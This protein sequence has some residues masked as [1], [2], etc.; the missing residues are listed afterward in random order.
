[1]DLNFQEYK[2]AKV[3]YFMKH[4]DFF[5]FPTVLVVIL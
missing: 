5:F 4:K 1:M 3:R 2:I